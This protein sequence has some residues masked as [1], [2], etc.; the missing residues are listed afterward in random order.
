MPLG[1]NEGEAGLILHPELTTGEVDGSLELM[2]DG[3]RMPAEL[4]AFPACGWP[5]ALVALLGDGTGSA[6]VAL[7]APTTDAYENGFGLLVLKASCPA[8]LEELVRVG[9]ARSAGSGRPIGDM[10]I[11]APALSPLPADA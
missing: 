4:A 7:L 11:A 2:M 10:P 1:T 8:A 9:N 6:L 3:E 5:A